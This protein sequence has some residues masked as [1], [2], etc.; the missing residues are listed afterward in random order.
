MKQTGGYWDSGCSLEEE[1]NNPVTVYACIDPMWGNP[2]V[3]LD[4]IGQT[5]EEAVARAEWS[6][7][8]SLYSGASH[9]RVP[10]IKGDWSRLEKH[11]YKI[12]RVKIE[13]INE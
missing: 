6:P 1:P 7:D 2:K 4:T 5:H 3:M 13:I 10:P 11:G 9:V 12:A 8:A